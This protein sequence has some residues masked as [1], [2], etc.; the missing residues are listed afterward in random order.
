ML[1]SHVEELGEEELQP[2]NKLIAFVSIEG[3]K[4]PIKSDNPDYKGSSYNVLEKW[5]DGS[6]SYEPLDQVIQDNPVTLA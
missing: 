6:E 1:S 2:Q 4:G 3:H 5:E